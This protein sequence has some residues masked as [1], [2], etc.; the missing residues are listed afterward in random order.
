MPFLRICSARIAAVFLLLAPVL[1][2][3]A[4]PDTAG[5]PILVVS[6]AIS[7]TAKDGEIEF[8]RAAL[9]R[10]DATPIDTKTPWFDGVSHFEGVRLDRLMAAVGATGTIVAA[11]AINDYASDIPIEDFAKYGA[12]LAYKRNG[13]YMTIRDK[14][15]LFL[16]YPYDKDEA[17]QSK[18]FY[19]RS[20]WQVKRLVVR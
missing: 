18:T 10:L 15:P 17:L 7:P 20:V 3:A 8:D 9:E 5:D 16:V 13:Q 11:V 12:I 19:A 4:S 14:G 2:Q 6:G 1:A